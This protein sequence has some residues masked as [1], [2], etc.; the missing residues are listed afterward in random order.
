MYLVT[1]GRC[2]KCHSFASVQIQYLFTRL[3][4]VVLFM[5][6][7]AIM[8]L[9]LSNLVRILLKC[10]QERGGVHSALWSHCSFRTKNVQ[11]DEKW[12]SLEVSCIEPRNVLCTVLICRKSVTR[13]VSSAPAKSRMFTGFAAA[14]RSRTKVGRLECHLFTHLCIVVCLLMSNKS[15]TALATDW[16]L[17]WMMAL[18]TL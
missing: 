1:G 9:D 3:K 7:V 15:S 5:C 13:W 8:Q 10:S 17:C 4:C 11:S 16:L 12:P 6:S 14:S 18:Q 2:K